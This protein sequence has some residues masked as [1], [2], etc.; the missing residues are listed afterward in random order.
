MTATITIQGYGPDGLFVRAMH[1]QDAFVDFGQVKAKSN[2]LWKQFKAD[3]VP[4]LQLF[5]SDGGKEK[6]V[7]YHSNFH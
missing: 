6:V 4:Y 5:I 2:E 7:F 1:H 3:D